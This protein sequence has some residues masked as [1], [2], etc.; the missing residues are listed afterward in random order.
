MDGV[1][2]SVALIVVPPPLPPP[3]LPPPPPTSTT[4]AAVI[5]SAAATEV[6]VGGTLQLSAT[7]LDSSDTVLEG[8]QFEWS[9]GDGLKASVSPTGEVAGLSPGEV[10]IRATTGGISGGLVITVLPGAPPPPPPPPTGV[11][12]EEVASGLAFP[13][14]LTSPPADERLFVVEK[15]GAIRVIKGGALLQ[16]PFLDLTGQVSLGGEQGLLGLAFP[17][18]YAT[19]GRFIV[20]FTDVNGDTRISSFRVSADPD[21]ADASSETLLLGVD[22]PYG[23]HNGGQIAFGPDGYLYVGLGDGG[24]Q[25]DPEGRGQSLDDLFGA[26]LRLDVSSG[27]SYTVRRTTRSSAGRTP[28]RR[29]G[30]TDCGTRGGSASIG[31]PE[32]CT[33]PTSVRATGRRSIMRPPME[34]WAAGPTTAGA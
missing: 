3:P 29:S 7:A 2:G 16:T 30:A 18:D 4:V 20:H 1:I 9:S 21:R 22:Q 12:L 5:V 32:T 10:E 26:I 31:R 34:A 13:L 6:L 28:A 14:Y 33:S 8:H 25:R 23:N 17:P 19:S 15:G 27:M 11:G 24:S